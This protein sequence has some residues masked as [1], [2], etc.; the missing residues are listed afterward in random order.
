M[1]TA[2][3][4][5]LIRQ[6]GNA[7]QFEGESKVSGNENAANMHADTA[8]SILDRIQAAILELNRS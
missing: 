8:D 1:K 6:Y 7:R 3:L 2:N 4:V 5:N